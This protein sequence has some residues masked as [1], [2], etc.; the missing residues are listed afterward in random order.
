MT[1]ELQKYYTERLSMMG[2][3]GWA[4]L[5]EDIQRMIDS[6]DTLSGVDDLQKLHF[7]KGEINIMN[8]LKSLKEISNAAYEDL[9]HADNE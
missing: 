8:W 6:T 1:P 2:G 7:R 5:I 3:Q 4:D 9:K